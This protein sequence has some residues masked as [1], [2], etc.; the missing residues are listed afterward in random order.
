MNTSVALFC[1]EG[2]TRKK[3]FLLKLKHEAK[4]EDL[5][6]MRRAAAS[7]AGGGGRGGG[8]EGRK[9]GEGEGGAAVSELREL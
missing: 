7:E 9:G 1:E 5:E 3:L 6:E 4:A 8:Q 2:E